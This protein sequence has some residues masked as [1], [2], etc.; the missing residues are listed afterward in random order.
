MKTTQCLLNTFLTGSL[1]IASMGL[2]ATAFALDAKEKR[3][4]AVK[5]EWSS[6]DSNHQLTV[7]RVFDKL[8]SSYVSVHVEMSCDGRP[9][10]SVT[11]NGCGADSNLS[12]MPGETFECAVKSTAPLTVVSNNASTACGFVLFQGKGPK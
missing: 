12:L 2:S 1:V 9:S 6:P 8:S 5:L 10:S 4:E 7:Y 3:A 11:V